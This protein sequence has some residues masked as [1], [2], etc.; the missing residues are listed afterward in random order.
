M[1]G[2][3]WRK[4]ISTI[5][6]L[7][8]VATISLVVSSSTPQQFSLEDFQRVLRSSLDSE[9][10]KITDE[11]FSTAQETTNIHAKSKTLMRRRASIQNREEDVIKSRALFDRR[12]SGHV[13]TSEDIWDDIVQH[14]WKISDT[15]KRDEGKSLTRTTYDDDVTLP[16]PFLVCGEEHLDFNDIVASFNKLE[17]EALLVSSSHDEFCLVLSITSVQGRE[18]IDSFGGSLKGVPLPDFT[19]IQPGTIDEVLS[20]GWSVPFSQE[21]V[22]TKK[23]N[24]TEMINHW[25]RIIIVDFTPEI[26]GMKEEADLLK[27]VNVITND[28]QDMGEVGWYEKIDE[29]EK[30][31]YSVDENTTIDIPSLSDVFSLT[32]I[33]TATSDNQR[34][35]FWREVFKNGIESKHVCS[36]M[37][38][39]LFV[40][41]RSGNY[42]F[43]LVLN[44]MD[45]PPAE[46]YESSASN[47]NCVASLVAA[48]SVHPYVLSVKAN[49]PTYHGWNVAQLMDSFK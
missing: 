6:L 19:K 20:M 32:A 35:R 5:V 47:P 30:Q 4:T 40:K 48:L 44:P 12:S 31:K 37:F 27:V 22:V 45:G 42:S 43:E 14:T 21:Q 38:S 3:H 9:L 8:Y 33:T 7:L 24:A 13:Y 29:E 46:E 16:I 28:I 41:A 1:I 17:E 49:F 36:T 15:I 10:D 18:V 39:T 23:S 26:S 25:E 34:I 11:K 2:L